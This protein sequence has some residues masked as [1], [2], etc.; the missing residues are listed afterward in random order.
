MDF[1]K[2]KILEGK[3]WDIFLHQ[4]QTSIGRLYFWYK[5]ECNDLL[6]IPE[7]AIIEFYNNAKKIK[8]ALIKLF[9][10]N[11]FNY[12]SLSNNTRH[13]HIHIIPRYSK[14]IKLFN[15]IFKDNSFGESYK[16][17]KD[18]IVSDEILI[19]IKEMI[20]KETKSES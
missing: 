18:F 7:E 17:N 15:I 16:R 11:M 4:D 9:K 6:D 5:K 20:L 12:L 13:L 3:Y 1:N 8:Y 14:E 10:P 2:L 19:K